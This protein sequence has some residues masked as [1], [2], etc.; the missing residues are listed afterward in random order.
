MKNDP[1]TF[2]ALLS[3]DRRVGARHLCRFNSLSPG[4]FGSGSGV[5][6][7][8]LSASGSRPQCAISKSWRLP[9]NPVGPSS[10]SARR[11][12]SAALP[13]PRFS[14]ALGEMLFREILAPLDRGE[15]VVSDL[16]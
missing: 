9:L 2:L 11:R 8:L 15:G 3:L 12:G 14:G 1:R 5:N 7:A 10:R 6:A 4:H 13:I 16:S